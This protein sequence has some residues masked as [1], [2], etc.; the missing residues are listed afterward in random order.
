[1]IPG[2]QREPQEW[3]LYTP[4]F[5]NDDSRFWPNGSARSPGWQ[6]WITWPGER[7][8]DFVWVTRTF[9]HGGAQSWVSVEEGKWYMVHQ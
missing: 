2:T 1:M 9:A 3:L 6:C 8:F 5:S 7:A 4:A